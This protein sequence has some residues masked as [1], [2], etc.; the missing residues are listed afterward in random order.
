MLFSRLMKQCIGFDLCSLLQ[1][2]KMS[3]EKMT[4][5]ELKLPSSRKEKGESNPMNRRRGKRFSVCFLKALWC[6]E[7]K[8]EIMIIVSIRFDIIYPVLYKWRGIFQ[9]NSQ[10]DLW[11]E[12]IVI[13]TFKLQ[14]EFP[15]CSNFEGLPRLNAYCTFCFLILYRIS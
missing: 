10:W 7:R 9:C 4:Y 6:Q 8:S 14:N 11:Q 12:Q 2:S 15:F 13:F 3:E 1:L 5:L